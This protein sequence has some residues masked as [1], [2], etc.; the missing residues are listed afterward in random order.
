MLDATRSEAE[1]FADLVELTARPGYAH[2][3]A[4]ICFRDNLVIFKSDYKA[5]SLKRLF[6][7]DRLNRSEIT[8]LLGLMVRQRL[9][10]SPLDEA[11]LQGYVARTDQLMSELHGAMN[12][13]I[14]Q[15]MISHA[16]AGGEPPPFGQGPM[17]RESIFYGTESAYS[18]QYR[19]FFVE[20]HTPDDDWLSSKMG[21]NSSQARVISKSMCSL[22]DERATELFRQTRDAGTP[23]SNMLSIYEFSPA[24]VVQRCGESADIVNAFF[25]VMTFDGDNSS[26]K[27]L[28]DYNALAGA[29]FI[30]SG[31]GTV[32]LFQHYSVYEALYES[33]FFW[34]GSDE[35]YR[36]TA[37][38][39]RGE[40]TEKFSERRLATVFGKP[41]VHRNVNLLRGK[42]IVGEADV[43]VIFGDRIIVV[44]A[45]SKKLTLAARKGNDGLLKK[46]FAAAIQKANEQAWECASA[47]L[48]GDC[49]LQD[50]QG[51]EVKLPKT[52]KEIF[53]FC[54]VSDHYPA[55]AFQVGQYLQ[56]QSTD[57]VR[58]PLVM[59]VFL[60]DVL[61]EM[62]SSPLHLLSYLRLRATAKTALWVNHELTALAYHL[63]RNL[64]LDPEFNVVMLEDDIAG[65]LDAAMT[66]RREGFPGS[67]TPS[68][69]LTAMV[70]SMYEKLILQIERRPHPATLELGFTLLSL[71][72]DSCRN[73]HLG[74]TSITN[75]SKADRQNHN[76]TLGASSRSSGICF[77]CNPEL[78]DEAIKIL[79]VQCHK[80]KYSQKAIT[81]FGVS[82]DPFGT[83]Q[84]GINLDFPWSHSKEM[85]EAVKGM[86]Q[87]TSIA[88]ALKAF[89]RNQR[90]SSP[91]RNDP[92]PCG[93]G[94]KFKK[95]CLN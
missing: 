28:G 43:L 15:W 95:C 8:T 22:M 24:E 9:E 26:F 88:A 68:G 10:L 80:R 7:S 56:F 76:F 44:Q 64:W 32:L 37:L 65:E 30:P 89:E 60:L 16:N 59:D 85:D 45:K 31:R 47:M 93:S 73:I 50:D 81:W 69:I 79:E 74:L 23:P 91:K 67:A 84:I 35:S 11:T 1:V 12:Q 19:D 71:S 53:P 34:M 58:P 25:R 55:L 66:V 39:H 82:V 92:C 54:V 46:D 36:Q 5:E 61:T 52:I 94:K 17:M 3:I 63:K 6:E 51:R 21:F 83:I 75:Q 38:D 87:A 90:P 18:F 48:S 14:L 4:F 27:E 62:L 42:K 13:S 57:V 70:G 20:K 40:F 29:P 77:H 72:E 78:S 49:H 2:A 86:K 33:P 41:N